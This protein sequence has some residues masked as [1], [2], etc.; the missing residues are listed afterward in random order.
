[1]PTMLPMKLSTHFP[2]EVHHVR[3]GYVKFQV[4]LP[5]LFLQA[6]SHRHFSLV[7]VCRGNIVQQTRSFDKPDHLN[8]F[9]TYIQEFVPLRLKIAT[10]Q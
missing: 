3:I 7:T 10:D 4:N 8:L 1:M 9:L 6:V 5:L 2:L